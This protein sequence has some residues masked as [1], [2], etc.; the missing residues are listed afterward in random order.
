MASY[1]PLT[2]PLK[3]LP[4]SRIRGDGGAAVLPDVAAVI[5]GKDDRLRH[6]DGT[7]ADFLA[8]DIE[9]HLAPPAEAVPR[10]SASWARVTMVTPCVSANQA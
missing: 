9:G 7:F 2:V 3:A 1:T 6:W 8:V 10:R 4:A 5:G